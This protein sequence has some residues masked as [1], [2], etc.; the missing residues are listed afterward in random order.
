MVY[1]A[2]PSQ[3]K[4]GRRSEIHR[5]DQINITGADEVGITRIVEIANVAARAEARCWIQRSCENLTLIATLEGSSDASPNGRGV[6]GARASD[7]GEGALVFN[8]GTERVR[9]CLPDLDTP[10]VVIKRPGAPEARIS[11]IHDMLTDIDHE[12]T[13]GIALGGIDLRTE[14]QMFRGPRH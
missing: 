8:H 14:V 12:L 5:I 7:A 13:A 2:P 6:V 10:M 11:I 9:T 1:P 4:T 3:I